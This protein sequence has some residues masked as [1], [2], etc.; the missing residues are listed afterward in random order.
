MHVLHTDQNPSEQ[1]AGKVNKGPAQYRSSSKELIRKTADE[2][3]PGR[4]NKKAFQQ[5]V[6]KTPV[7][8]RL[9]GLSIDCRRKQPDIQF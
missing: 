3:L 5:D 4:E 2:K 6:L 7:A 8:G 9:R 1:S